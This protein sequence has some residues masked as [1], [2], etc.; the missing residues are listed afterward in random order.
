VAVLARRLPPGRRALYQ[1]FALNHA[2]TPAVG[3]FV[4]LDAT[5]GVERDGGAIA[6]RHRAHL[7]FGGGV[8]RG[9]LQAGEQADGHQQ[10]GGQGASP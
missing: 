10:A 7:A 6:Q 5:V 1:Y 2:D 4:N 3:V 9:H 8:G